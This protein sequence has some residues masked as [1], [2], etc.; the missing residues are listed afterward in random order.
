LSRD[1]I[2]QAALELADREGLEALT[3]QR[4][5]SALGVGTM[6]LY[7]YFR[8]KDELLDAVVDA[9]V[10]DLE[11]LG[12]E[13]SWREQLREL[14]HVARGMLSRHPGL[15]QLRFRQPV[16]RPEALR[17]SEAAL[18]ILLSAGFDRG[19]AAQAFRLLFTY[20]FGFAGLSPEETAEEAR[21]QAAGAIVALPPDKYPNLTKAAAEASR[22]M[23]GEEQFEYGLDR[24]L[25]GLE[26]RLGKR[27]LAPP[28]ADE[29]GGEPGEAADQ[30]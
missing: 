9:A 28:A 16:L 2:A 19:E 10:E 27:G 25:D 1:E 30:G 5:A 23:A 13:G 6:T 8:S 20:T 18:G 29:G 14:V 15:V 22:A 11:P 24:I 17:F 21:R 4:V 3:M 26:A 7:G 12:G